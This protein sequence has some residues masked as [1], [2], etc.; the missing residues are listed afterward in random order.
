MGLDV[1][2]SERSYDI[3]LIV[4]FENRAGYEIYDKHPIHQLVRAFMHGIYETS[5][6][7]DFERDE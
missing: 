5:V 6:A 3:V 4:D 1:K 2:K 7:V